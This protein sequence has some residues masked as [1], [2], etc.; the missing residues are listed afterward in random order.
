MKIYVKLLNEGVDVW[1]P[2]EADEHNNLYRITSKTMNDDENWEFKTGEKV[3]VKKY[4]FSDGT[5]GLVAIEL[6]NE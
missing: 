4:K 6:I 3:K 5:R 1:R 2:V